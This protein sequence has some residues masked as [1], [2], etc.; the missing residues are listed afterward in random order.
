MPPSCEIP[1]SKLTRVRVDG[2]VKIIASVR[3]SSGRSAT[4]CFE[5]G[6]EPVGEVEDGAQL[7]RLT[8]R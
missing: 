4:P 3:P 7:V 8:S 5:A 6:L 2:F 1:T